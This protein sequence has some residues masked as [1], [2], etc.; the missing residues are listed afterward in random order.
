[1]HWIAQSGNT[2]YDALMISLYCTG[3]QDI[4]SHTTGLETNF[5]PG[6]NGLVQGSQ[7]SA[8]EDHSALLISDSAL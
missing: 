4:N 5:I 2:E 7:P 3:I 1:M 6:I 8:S